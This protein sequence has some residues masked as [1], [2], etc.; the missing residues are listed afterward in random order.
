M[1]TLVY[2][3]LALRNDYK[4]ELTRLRSLGMVNFILYKEIYVKLYTCE[5]LLTELNKRRKAYA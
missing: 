1:E 4:D 2:K 5:V 3:L